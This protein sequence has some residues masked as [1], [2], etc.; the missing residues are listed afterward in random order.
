[1]SADET[2]MTAITFSTPVCVVL[3][4]RAYSDKT[5]DYSIAVQNYGTQARLVHRWKHDDGM[6]FARSNCLLRHA[7]KYQNAVMQSV[8]FM[9]IRQTP[10]WCKQNLSPVGVRRSATAVPAAAVRRLVVA[11]TSISSM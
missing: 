5:C 6:S 1:M 9:Y 3:A 2:G 4:R 8:I 10:F 11:A 7:A